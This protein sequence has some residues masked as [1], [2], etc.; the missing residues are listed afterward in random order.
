MPHKERQTYH[1]DWVY[2]HGTDNMLSISIGYD[3]IR[4]CRVG[5]SWNDGIISPLDPNDSINFYW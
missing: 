3:A 5:S 2:G 1:D 4:F